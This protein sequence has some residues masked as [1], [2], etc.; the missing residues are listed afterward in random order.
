MLIISYATAVHSIQVY[1][2]ITNDITTATTK[3]AIVPTPI[4]KNDADP[5][6]TSTE[7]IVESK[8]LNSNMMVNN[9]TANE[10]QG[11]SSRKKESG[12]IKDS[13]T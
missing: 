13:R 9:T 4:V 10:P 1:E 6:E 8:I 7:S 3:L 11:K 5:K 12:N 2:N